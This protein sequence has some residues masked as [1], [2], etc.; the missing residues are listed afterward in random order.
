MSGLAAI[1]LMD[2][3]DDDQITMLWPQPHLKTPPIN[4]PVFP[5]I[6][7]PEN[8]LPEVPQEIPVPEIPISPIVLPKQGKKRVAKA[9][10]PVSIVTKIEP[11]EPSPV[12]D[13]DQIE[14]QT[15]KPA[16]VSNV[17]K[18]ETTIAVEKPEIKKERKHKLTPPT[19]NIEPVAKKPKKN[20]EPMAIKPVK[21][22]EPVLM[23]KAR[24]DYKMFKY[25]LPQV[26]KMEESFKMDKPSTILFPQITHTAYMCENCWNKS[27]KIPAVSDR[28]C[29]K[30]TI[31]LC[32]KCIGLN[33]KIVTLYTH[34]MCDK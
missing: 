15:K 26:P 11:K 18:I 8:P 16:P 9:K 24:K 22:V 5:E 19:K 12:S 32:E 25:C 7:A 29:L 34:A 4:G 33:T 2:L 17:D 6:P 23:K 20:V 28:K 14:S 31:T 21:K 3:L 30:I 27:K 10:K 1:A 13:V